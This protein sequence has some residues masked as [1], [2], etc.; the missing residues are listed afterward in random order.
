MLPDTPLRFLFTGGKTVAFSLG[1]T[2]ENAKSVNIKL[3]SSILV[4]LTYKMYKLFIAYIGLALREREH[5]L[6]LFQIYCNKTV[7]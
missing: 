2:I 1:S 5:L 6:L 4:R 7:P 3:Q